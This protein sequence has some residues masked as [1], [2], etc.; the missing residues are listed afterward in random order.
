LLHLVWGIDAIVA[1]ICS[2]SIF[3]IYNQG[4]MFMLKHKIIGAKAFF[5]N[6]VAKAVLLV[7]GMLLTTPLS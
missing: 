5:D 2:C 7:L 4:G 1:L 6:W 3:R